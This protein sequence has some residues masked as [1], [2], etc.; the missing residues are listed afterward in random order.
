ME[1]R[2][3]TE[4]RCKYKCDSFVL[5]SEINFCDQSCELKFESKAIRI[6]QTYLG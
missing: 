4:A 2:D 5:R 3:E 6:D 1:Q